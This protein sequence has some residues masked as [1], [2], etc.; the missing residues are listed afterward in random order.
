MADLREDQ[1]LFQIGVEERT[2]EL[3]VGLVTKSI[4][5]NILVV[6]LGNIVV[7]EML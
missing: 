7:A 2:E 6:L 5:I 4:S 3:H 1:R